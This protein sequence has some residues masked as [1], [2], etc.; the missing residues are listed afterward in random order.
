MRKISANY[1]MPV[2]SPPLRNGIVVIDDD[3][4][5]LEVIDTGGRLRESSHLEFYKGMIT[6]GFVLPCYRSEGKADALTASAF[7][8]FD[9]M[10]LQQ[11]IKGIG[12]IERKA[13]H[14]AAK[15]ESTVSYHTILEL[16][17][18]P[19]LEEFDV[20]QQGIDLI[21]EGWN[22]YNQACSVSCCTSSL[23]ETD[24]AAYILQYAA[25]HQLVIPLENTQQ[26]SMPEQLERLKQQMG[27]VSEDPPE[28]IKRNAHLVLIHDRAVLKAIADA[29][30][31]E[32]LATF[33]IPR[34]KQVPNI[35][36]AMLD[37]QE[38]SPGYSLPDVIPA[39]TLKAAEILFEEQTLGSI[40]PGK[41]PGLNL[42]SNI[43]P[44]TFRLTGE[45]TFR[46]LV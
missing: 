17:T 40:E 33:H 12:I 7:R 45:S 10:L 25:G 29:E 14:F 26:W 39:F 43:E 16:C 42:I 28:G 15:M 1:I 36:E 41:I 24:I 27:R 4:S 32:V 31:E 21:A 44:G 30:S 34:P 38:S 20:Y 37:L 13:G 5:I 3:G 35:L 11:G 6:P 9:R 8:D 2:S 46:V 18:V 22:E 23:M 19:D